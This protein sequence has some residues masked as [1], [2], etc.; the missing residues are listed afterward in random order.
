MV[1]NEITRQ[2]LID[3]LNLLISDESKRDEVADWAFSI[4]DSNSISISDRLIWNFLTKIGGV[5]LLAIGREFLYMQE[6]FY[7]WI[8]YLENA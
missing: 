3:K 1:S 2:E 6:D 5:D 7:S 4:I 8:N